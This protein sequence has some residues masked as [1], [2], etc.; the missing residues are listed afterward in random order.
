MEWDLQTIPRHA[1]PS[2]KEFAGYRRNYQAAEAAYAALAKAFEGQTTA[3]DR[4][5]LGDRRDH[6]LKALRKTL[7]IV[8]RRLP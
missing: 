1:G 4:P 6:T 3:F 2:K 5:D 8:R 7:D